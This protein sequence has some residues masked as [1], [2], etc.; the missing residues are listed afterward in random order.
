MKAVHFPPELAGMAVGVHKA[1]GSS[2]AAQAAALAEQGSCAP[3]SPGLQWQRLACLCCV[4]TGNV[5][6]AW[7]SNAGAYAFL[8]VL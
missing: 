7:I 1:K 6:Q 3:A 2:A 4:V 5:G 8:H